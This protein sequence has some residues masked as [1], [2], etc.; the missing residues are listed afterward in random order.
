MGFLDISWD[1]RMNAK[2]S[3]LSFLVNIRQRPRRTPDYLAMWKIAPRVEA[4][5]LLAVGLGSLYSLL[6]QAV[7]TK[8][9]APTHMIHGIW[10]VGTTIC[11]MQNAG[12]LSAF[13]IEPDIP[14]ISS[15]KVAV[16]VAMT[17]P[18][19]TSRPLLGCLLPH[20]QDRDEGQDAVNVSIVDGRP[21]RAVM[22]LLPLSDP[23][24]P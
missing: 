19:P 3:A 1:E 15:A 20:I 24:P 7:G 10:A 17:V 2:P 16:F 22:E 12:Y 18:Q 8:E 13:G 6:F 5:L 14:Q 23:Y 11:H 9:V 4:N 21:R